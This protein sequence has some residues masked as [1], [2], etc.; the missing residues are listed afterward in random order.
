MTETV[1]FTEDDTKKLRIDMAGLNPKAII[2][3]ILKG[4]GGEK[5]KHQINQE[6][7][8]LKKPQVVMYLLSN[9]RNHPVWNKY[10]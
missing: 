3:E 10:R 8:G 6:T 2:K 5:I 7:Q 9:F 4:E 1:L